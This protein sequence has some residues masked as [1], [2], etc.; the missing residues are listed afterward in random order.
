MKTLIIA[1]IL[2]ASGLGFALQGQVEQHPIPRLI[3]KDGR[4]ALLV[5]GAPYLILGAQAN[6]SSDW[7]AM[8]PK[9]WSAIE[10]LHA[11]TLEIPIYWEQF[12]PQPGKFDY[13]AMDTILLKPANIMRILCCSGSAPGRTA[14]STICPSG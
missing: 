13:T 4:F 12:E 2:A 3:Q 8:L 1:A 9:V 6:N 10:F 14:V 5:D 7:P 11:N